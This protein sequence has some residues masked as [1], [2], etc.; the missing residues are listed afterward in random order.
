MTA[1]ELMPVATF[2]GERGWGYDGLYTS[3]PHP[4]YGGPDGPRA[5]RRRRAPR[6]ARRDPGRRLQPHRAR[7]RGAEAFAP[8]FTDRF[9]KTPWGDALDYGQPGV[10]EWAIQ[11]AE[12]WVRDYGIDGLRLDAVHAL[13]DDSPRHVLAELAER[14]RAVSPRALVISEMAISKPDLRPLSRV[15]SRRDVARRP[16]PRAARGA[17]GRAGGLLRAVRRLAGLRSPP[18]SSVPEGARIVACAQNHDQVGNRALG[19]RLPREQLRVAAAVVLFSPFTPLLFQGEE[20]GEQAPFQFFT[21]H[22]DPAIAEATREGRRREF[23]ALRGLPGRGARPAG[24]RRRSSARSCTP[25]DPGSALPRAAAR[26]AASSRASSRSEVDE[27]RADARAPPRPRDAACRFRE[28]HRRARRLRVW[29]GSRFRSDRGGTG[30]ER[31]SRSS[32]RTREKVELCLFDDDDR[33]TRYALTE[34]TAFHWHGYLPGIG[35]GPAL[36]LSRARPLGAGAGPPLQ[37]VQAADR[38]VCEVDRGAGAVGARQRA[39][40]R[41]ERRERGRRARRRGR[42]RRD[43]EV[44]R[45]RRVASTGRT[46]PIRRRRGTRR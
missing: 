9:G 7:Q 30:R 45:D 3:A 41:A 46:T 8:Y 35:P 44:G 15:G 24:S 2:P 34:R 42:R 29:P 4:A 43:S 21:D 17:D 11:N 25:R 38:P 10:R 1:I 18:S 5:A 39:P 19:D 26:C 37:P 36:R 22:I 32:A 33:E 40:V 20:Y 28:P 23:A 13:R 14:V 31:T 6:G 27:E 12:L 16:S